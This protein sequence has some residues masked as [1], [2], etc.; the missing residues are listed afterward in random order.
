MWA[1]KGIWDLVPG[2]S[3]A[4]WHWA[5]L[6]VLQTFAS[7]FFSGVWSQRMDFPP[8]GR[9]DS[10]VFPVTGFALLGSLPSLPLSEPLLTSG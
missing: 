10:A 4:G 8:R 7:V 2:R 9:R 1:E 6:K 3:P 5:H